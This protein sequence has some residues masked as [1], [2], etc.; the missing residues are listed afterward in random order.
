MK[1]TLKTLLLMT[2][3][4]TT[5]PVMGQNALL[6]EWNT[7]YQTPPFSQIKTEHYKPAMK[8]AI[9]E[10]K[11]NI[12]KIVKQKAAP[13]FDNTIL[14]LEQASEKLDRV[15][16]V[17]FNLNECNTNPEMQKIVMDMAP[18]LSRFSSEVSMNERLFARVKSVY[19]NRAS[20]NLNAEQLQLL[21]KHYKSFTRNGALLSPEDKKTMAKYSEEE[22][23]LTNKFG[24]NALADNNSY[25]LHVTD[26]S[27]LSGLPENVVA[28]AKAEA[29]SRKMDGWVFTLAYPSYGPFMTYADNRNLREQIYHAYNSQG[30][31]GNSNDNNEIIRRITLLRHLQSNLM[32][33]KCYADYSL[34]E[35]MASNT[36]NVSDLMKKL[37]EAA[38][39][40]AIQDLREVQEYAN[41]HGFEGQLQRW[42]FSY[43][44]KKLEKEKYSFDAELL[45]PYFQLENVRRGIFDLYGRLYGLTFKEANNIDKY[46]PDVT[47]YEVFDGNHFMGVL[48]LDM[49]PRASKRSGAWM[50]EFRNQSNVNGKEIRPLIQVVC[51]FSKPVG[52]KPAL[53]SF[54]EVET[55]MHEFGHAMHGMLS[56]V[57]YNTL[58]GTSVY[59]DFVELPSQVMENWC[60]EPEF[61]N[62]FAKHYQTGENIPS[63]YI[64]KIKASENYLAGYLCIRQISLGMVD[65]AF[66]TLTEPLQ[67]RVEDF[68][69]QHMIELLPPVE[70]CNTSTAFTHIFA[71]GYAA[72]YYSYKW[73]EVLD[74]D[75]FS[76]FKENGIFDKKTAT[77][78][79]NEVLSKGATQHPAQL[80]RNFMGRDPNTEALLIHCGFI[81]PASMEKGILDK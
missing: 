7:P 17:L 45:R 50:T 32:G 60:Y 11:A 56:Q 66:H 21:E 54:D 10:A 65:M 48:Y 53:L 61:L 59:R 38:Y 24:Q 72:G 35:T 52:D 12:N 77:A 79:R 64:E 36:E 26:K 18:E 34:A 71:G 62:T 20:E 70:G 74:A 6:E 39:P 4:A 67:G 43:W 13:T 78:F 29:E 30:N 1:K 9:K 49:F 14:A 69:R 47:V 5:A 37:I 2:I 55:F 75:V 41:K 76:K 57:T 31:R 81:K 63:E 68:E 16:S 73:S 44:S 33:Y 8:A 58:A 27:D 28:A 51:N 42:D 46:H 23:V 22:S 19:D 15:S 80:F 25:T 3:L 40:V